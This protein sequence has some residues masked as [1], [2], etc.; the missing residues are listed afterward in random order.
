MEGKITI[1]RILIFIV[2]AVAYKTNV[3]FKLYIFIQTKM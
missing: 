1:Y 3:F 2:N